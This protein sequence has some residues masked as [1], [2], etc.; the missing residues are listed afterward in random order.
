M[1]FEGLCTFLCPFPA[2]RCF[3]CRHNG[4][5]GAYARRICCSLDKLLFFLFIYHILTEQ[6]SFELALAGYFGQFEV[7]LGKADEASQ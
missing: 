2:F 6:Q 1:D 3:C 5:P 7:T 4:G